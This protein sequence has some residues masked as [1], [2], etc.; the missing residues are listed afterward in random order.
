MTSPRSTTRRAAPLA[1]TAAAIA[2]PVLAMTLLAPVA[3]AAEAPDDPIEAG[4]ALLDR[5]GASDVAT[6]DGPVWSPVATGFAA[7][8]TDELPHG[9]TGGAGGDLVVV[10][11]A[12]ALAEHAASDEPLTI[13]VKGD[14]EIGDGD[15]ITVADDKTI[16]GSGAKAAIVDGGLFI[17]HASNVIVRNLTFRDSY[18]P[19]DWDGKFDDNDNDGIRVDTSDHVWIDHNDFTRIG[20]GET[21]LRKDSTALTLS[22]NTYRDH[23]KA[24]G[25]GWTDNVVTTLTMHHNLISN[26]YQRN[27]SIDNVAYG[28]L[29][30]N[31]IE[32]IGQYG[33]MSRGAS[34]LLVENSSYAH[35]EDAIVAKDPESRVHSRGNRF[36]DIRG[37][38]QNTGP[39]F[40][41]SDFYDYALD[42]TTQVEDL[43]KTHAGPVGPPENIPRT[44]TVALD[45]SGDFASIG[46]ALGAAWRVD[47]PVDIEIEPGVYRE[48]VRIWPGIDDV[49]L[50]G[51][52]GDAAD[53]V[54]TYDLAA[55][56]KKFYGDD[57]F[58][59]TGSPTLSV[60]ADDVTLQ[61]I[62]IENAYDE[63]A[64]GP[65]QALALR[66]VGDR[67][68]LDGVRL[69]GNQD[70]FLAGPGGDEISRVY[71]TDSYIEGDVDFIYGG[72]TLVVEDS[73]IRSLDRG[74]DTNNGY[75]AAPATVPGSHG[76]LFVNS[77]FTSDAAD[78]SVYLGRPWHPSS[79]PNV[80]PSMLVR[81]SWLGAHIGTPAWSDMSG[82]PWRE[83][84]LNEYANS[85]PG[86]I[87]AGSEVDG[88][89][90]LSDAEAADRTR[91]A[92]LAGDDGWTPWR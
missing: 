55:G 67:V 52:T 48:V 14:I 21:D 15:M 88:R 68:V 81:D 41:A 11:D 24:V 18:V 80:A 17:D 40:E 26:S 82:W 58:G 86:A 13:L 46:A 7:T 9:T 29:Y 56:Q 42:G 3:H 92:Y 69:L 61:D 43:V 10:R 78:G 25:V 39:T 71:A 12:D 20:D 76:F 53:V 19:G 90:H 79:D 84:D 16:A 6:A 33:T 54:I 74:S 32:G 59:H 77:R 34:Q 31:H 2:A 45:G 73:E 5:I 89:P 38:K 57:T 87:G 47:H 37:L 49:T 1:R 65:S 70:T 27:G 62:T 36:T 64:N 51:A 23:N 22:W 75:V 66:T 35:G 8:P 28:H 91:D 44:V 50:R 85:G 83:D 30:N 60:L 63:E 72:G 4:A